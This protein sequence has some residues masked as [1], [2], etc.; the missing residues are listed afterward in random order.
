MF[1]RSSALICGL[2][3]AAPVVLG[4]PTFGDAS[5]C[6]TGNLQCCQSLQSTNNPAVQTLAGLLGVILPNV[7]GMAGLN[8]DPISVLGAGGNSCSAQPACCTGDQ[9]NGALVLGCNPLNANI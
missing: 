9:M 3:L 6:D 7:A 4:V 5:A 1:F 8:C 2:F